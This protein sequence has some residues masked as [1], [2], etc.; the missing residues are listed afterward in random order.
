[1]NTGIKESFENLVG[2]AMATYHA[3]GL[4]IAIINGNGKTLYTGLFGYRDEE[5][6]L[7]VTEDTIFGMASVTKSF[8]C[9]ALLQLCEKGVV[10]LNASVSKYLPLLKDERILVRHLMDHSAGFFP[11]PR[12][13][14]TDV[15]TD[16]GIYKNCEEDFSED[17]VLAEEGMKRIIER[18]NNVPIRLGAPGEYMSYSNDG[19]GLMSELIRIYGGEESFA[20]Y[21]KKHILEPLGMIRSSMN[22]VAPFSD[23]NCTSLYLDVDG[24]HTK[25][26]N[27]Y[28]NAFVLHGGGALRSTLRDMKSYLKMYINGQGPVLSPAIYKLM[29]TPGPVYGYGTR[30]CKGFSSLKVDSYDIFAHNGG[31]TGISNRILWCPELK[32]GVIAFCNKSGFPIATIAHQALRAFALGKKAIAPKPVKGSKLADFG[33]DSEKILGEYLSGEAAYCCLTEDDGRLMISFKQGTE[34][35]PAQV[36]KDGFIASDKPF[37][38]NYV[39]ALTLSSGIQAIRYGGRIFPKV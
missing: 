10:D 17:N 18:L 34:A 20:A 7:P 16:M 4:A 26:N 32:V 31:L 19:Y 30:Y 15:A 25:R 37:S 38:N 1:M 3:P 8:T 24:V 28:D 27:F 13:L 22:F 23:S 14:L 9:L 36:L 35:S 12:M 29:T 33:P 21:V 2:N 5:K 11:L 6:R 39:Q